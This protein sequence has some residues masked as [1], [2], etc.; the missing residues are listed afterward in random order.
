[1]TQTNAVQIE[2]LVVGTGAECKPGSTVKV[3]YKGTLLNGTV[4][5]SSY[6]SGQPITF[7]LNNLIA[8]WQEG[9]PGMK[10]GGKRKLT[11]P[12]MKAYGERGIPGAIP[13]KSDLLFEIELLGLK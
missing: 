9:I 2:D 3:H 4:F 8:G 12:Y 7:P 11:I 6:D 5:D 10:I 13:P 1:M